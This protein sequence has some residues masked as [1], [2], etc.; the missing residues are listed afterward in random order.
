MD[1]FVLFLVGVSL[2]LNVGNAANI[3]KLDK[4]NVIKVEK[5]E[6][7]KCR[8]SKMPCDSESGG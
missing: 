7:Q 5:S 6:F 1:P 4:H 8:E 2:I 3:K